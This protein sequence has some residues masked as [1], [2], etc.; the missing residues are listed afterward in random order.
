MVHTSLCWTPKALFGALF[1]LLLAVMAC[2]PTG[3]SDP[4]RL[5]GADSDE[6]GCKASAGYRWSPL[7]GECVRIW[8]RGV[9]LDPQDSS[10]DQTMAAY[11]LFDTVQSKAELHLPGVGQ[12][13]QM[14][15]SG[16]EGAHRWEADSLSLYPWKGFVLRVR[17]RVLYHGQ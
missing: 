17:D 11:V 2:S 1:T 12:P 14:A 3:S 5:P 9:R 7:L 13:I 6:H 15:R 4:P 10:L 16:E 8:E